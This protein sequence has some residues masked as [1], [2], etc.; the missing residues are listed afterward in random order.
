[1]RT[2]FLLLLIGLTACC[3]QTAR[4]EASDASELFLNAYLAVQQ[5]EKFERGGKNQAALAKYRFAHSLLDQISQKNPDWQ[6][7]IVDYRR[8]KTAD[9]VSKL[10]QKVA[11]E[12]TG[13]E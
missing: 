8:R 13:E 5:G 12:G 3:A 7:L 10:E 6:P 4:A 1:M 11:S 9:S 2:L